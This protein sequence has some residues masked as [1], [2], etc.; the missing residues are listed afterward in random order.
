MV[1]LYYHDGLKTFSQPLT[2]GCEPAGLNL[3]VSF[4]GAFIMWTEK[5]SRYSTSHARRSPSTSSSKPYVKP[6][7]YLLTSASVTSDLNNSGYPSHYDLLNDCPIHNGF[8]HQPSIT[9]ASNKAL[10][11]VYD[12]LNQAS[13]LLVAWKERQSAIDLVTSNVGKLVRIARAVKRR[14]P[15]IVRRVMQ[16]NPKAKDIIKTPSG[17]WL[18]YHFA[19]VPTISDIHH[20]CGV[21]GFEFP[22]QVV[23]GVGSSKQNVMNQRYSNSAPYSPEHNSQDQWYETT[24]KIGGKITAMNPNVHLA[25][26]LGFGQPLSVAWEMTPFSWFVDY[27][28]NVG[29]LINN[30][31]PQFPGIT[32]SD[33]YTTIIQEGTQRFR[34]ANFYS[35][36]WVRPDHPW[37]NKWIYQHPSCTYVGF[38]MKRDL[39]W[40]SYGLEFSSPFDLS[41]QRCSYIV[42]VL[43][44]L[45]T[46]MKR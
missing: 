10:D 17:L 1:V 27:F 34:N 31:E 8:W 4:I 2:V 41:G 35:S 16:R 20:A 32:V 5:G 12:Q 25:T 11:K 22:V 19:I 18:E 3:L 24:V 30:L 43:G 40:P 23:E 36:A 7:K 29:Q 39:G 42:A 44:S 14:D 21:L 28:V 38:G 6:L 9:S 15:R 26:M 37:Y 33:K 13:D 46:S 45:L